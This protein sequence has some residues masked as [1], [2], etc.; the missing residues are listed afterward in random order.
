MPKLTAAEMNLLQALANG[1]TLKSHRYLD[2]SKEYQ[3][4]ALNGSI[5]EVPRASVEALV[6]NHLIDDNKKFP[7]ATYWLTETG[8]SKLNER[9]STRS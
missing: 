1:Y 4:H 5:T 9:P 7:A 3:L 8:I 2:G 6:E